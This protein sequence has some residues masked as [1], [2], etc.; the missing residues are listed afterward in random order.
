[1]SKKDLKKAV[2]YFSID[3]DYFNGSEHYEK[4]KELM[5][6]FALTEGYE[7]IEYFISTDDALDPPKAD[8]MQSYL[9]SQYEAIFFNTTSDL[10]YGSSFYIKYME[11]IPLDREDD[12]MFSCQYLD[13]PRKNGITEYHFDSRCKYCTDKN[14]NEPDECLIEGVFHNFEIQI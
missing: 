2:G 12:N 4:Q 5:E 7:I 3:A 6:N 9:E 8:M 10:K 1:M 11:I 13:V 14:C